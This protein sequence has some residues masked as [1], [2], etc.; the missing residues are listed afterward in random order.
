M[1]MALARGEVSEG[2]G[3]RPALAGL[4]AAELLKWRHSAFPWIALGGALC[5]PVLYAVGLLATGT[6]QVTPDRFLLMALG[7]M[8]TLPSGIVAA[9]IATQVFGTETDADT[10]K[11]VLTQPVP[12]T[13][14]FAVQTL[15]T[16]GRI[17]CLGQDLARAP[18]RVMHRVGCLIEGPAA[19]R[20][21]SAADNLR[22]VQNM[23]LGHL[24]A[25]ETAELLETVDLSGT[26]SKAAGNFSLGMR[27]RLGLAMALVGRPDLLILDEPT[28]GLDPAGIRDMR[29]LSHR[30][31]R[32][33][34]LTILLS[35]HL[36]HEIEQVATRVGVMSA[37]RLV[38]EA[39]VEGLRHMGAAAIEADVSHPREAAD[40]IR[41]RLGVSAEA[42]EDGRLI[43]RGDVRPA[44]IAALLVRNDIDVNR[45]S[46][47]ESSLEDVFLHLTAGN[48]HAA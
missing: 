32:E 21:L 47:A 20:H 31:V 2:S 45:L 29:A 26:G 39:A 28:N 22:I 3:R 10:W 40:L 14:V 5:V 43:V 38:A 30:L 4:V 9:L 24:D 7:W 46:R 36:L 16:R 12:R 1:E 42:G 27:Q 6:G 11:L 35:S 48:G 18:H 33:R 23:K 34:G 15:T 25:A 13:H 37:G 8:T 17:E 41:A 19:Y 44:D